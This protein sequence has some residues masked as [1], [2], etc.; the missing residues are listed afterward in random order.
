MRQV[1]EEP[2]I[3]EENLIEQFAVLF[4]KIDLNEI[5]VRQKFEEEITRLNKFQSSILGAKARQAPEEINIDI[6]NYAKYIL[7]EGSVPEKR[8]LLG[9]LRS[10]L[11][12]KNKT[13]TLE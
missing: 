5:G 4:D 1:C 3:R 13:I 11:I 6:R 7:R 10:R 9:N 12:Y 8:E 2:E